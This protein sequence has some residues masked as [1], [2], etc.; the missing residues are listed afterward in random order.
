MAFKLND[1]TERCVDCDAVLKPGQGL[2]E[3]DGVRCQNRTQCARRVVRNGDNRR[4]LKEVAKDYEN[5]G[6]LATQ[7]RGILLRD[8][9]GMVW[10]FRW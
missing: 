4:A 2:V 10:P 8:K 3:R 6:N 1:R 7:A 9:W 5:L